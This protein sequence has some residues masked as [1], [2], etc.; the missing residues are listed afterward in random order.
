[1]NL[2][3]FFNIDLEICGIAIDSRKTMDGYLFICVDGINNDGHQYASAAVE[4][5]AICVISNKKVEVSVPN[6]IVDDTSALFSKLCNAFYNY[7]TE[8]LTMIGITGTDGKTTTTSI[9]NQMLDYSGYIGTNGIIYNDKEYMLGHTTTP[10][11]DELFRVL[12]DMKNSG[13]KYVNLEVTS[14]AIALKRTSEIDFNVLGLTNITSE[15]LDMHGTLDNYIK[16]KLKMFDYD[17]NVKILNADDKYFNLFKKEI[18]S[19]LSYGVENNADYFAKNIICGIDYL[20]YT[21]VFDKKDY[22]VRVNLIGKFNVYNTL[23]AIVVC[24][25]LGYSIEETI[26][27]LQKV[28]PVAG[29]ANFING[30]HDFAVVIDFAH[31]PEGIRQ[32]TKYF[33]DL[34]KNVI[35]VIGSAGDRDKSKRFE[36]G[37]TV[38]ENSNHIILTNEDPRSEDELAIINDI[39][40]GCNNNNYEI[41]I[42]RTLA[43]KKAIDMAQTG[44]VVLLLGKG[45]ENSIEYSDGEKPY[46]EIG[47]VKDHLVNLGYKLD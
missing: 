27:M 5:G 35:S 30:D 14:H 28:K 39:A 15:H 32:I 23:L 16:T 31:T 8:N 3:D 47:V 24:H 4:N 7:P 19:Y 43:I 9:I 18:D 36:I 42:D 1:M 21:L 45:I 38:S 11:A 40:C 6:I 22:V 29:R 33:K 41:I 25:N 12:N 44:D 34:N 17:A 37:L 20:E 26:S 46:S 13:I 2:I 10:E